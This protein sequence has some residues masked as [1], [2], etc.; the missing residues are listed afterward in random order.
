GALGLP[1]SPT[2]RSSDLWLRDR[3]GAGVGYVAEL[4]PWVRGLEMGL[5]L[6]DRLLS[7]GPCSDGPP[8][9]APVAGE[10]RRVAVTV[11][12]LGSTSKIGRSAWRTRMVAHDV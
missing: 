2:R 6:A 10:P 3:A 1:A 9:V 5:D 4:N 11:G 12:G 7:P 8:P